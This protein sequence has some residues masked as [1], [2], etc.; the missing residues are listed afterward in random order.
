MESSNTN[1]PAA[2]ATEVIKL[3]EPKKLIESA[4]L[5]DPAESTNPTEPTKPTQAA[6]LTQ[7]AAMPAPFVSPIWQ[8]KQTP[9]PT[10]VLRPPRISIPK[11]T[12][13]QFKRK[14]EGQWGGSFRETMIG[15][16]VIKIPRPN[17][18]MQT[19]LDEISIT[20]GKC[21]DIMIYV[22]NACPLI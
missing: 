11:Q 18:V 14:V 8:T 21:K 19:L 6:Q 15:D 22:I 2:S 4:R 7:S 20:D 1:G 5:T 16:L 17:V 12:F 3:T 9:G 10:D 13:A